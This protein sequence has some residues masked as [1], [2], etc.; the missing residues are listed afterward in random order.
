MVR[1]AKS[2]VFTA[3]IAVTGSGGW[4]LMQ[5]GK[6]GGFGRSADIRTTLVDAKFCERECIFSS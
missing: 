1:D 3:G 5:S 4:T 2:G 6:A